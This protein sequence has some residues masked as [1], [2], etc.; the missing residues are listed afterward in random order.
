MSSASYEY[1]KRDCKQTQAFNFEHLVYNRLISDGR[2]I[3]QKP[4]KAQRG[5]T[6]MAKNSEIF[7]KIEPLL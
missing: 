2:K 6:L 1:E 5:R 7:Y 4:N 3:Y